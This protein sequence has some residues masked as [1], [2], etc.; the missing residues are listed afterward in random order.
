M[1][2]CYYKKDLSLLFY[3]FAYLSLCLIFALMIGKFFIYAIL[4]VIYLH[5]DYKN[6][7]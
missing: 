5:L 2:I 6:E 7:Y 1:L 3:L 4:P